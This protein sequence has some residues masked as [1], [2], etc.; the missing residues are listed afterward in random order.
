MFALGLAL[1]A[2]GMLGREYNGTSAFGDFVR[3][4]YLHMVMTGAFISGVLL[5]VRLGPFAR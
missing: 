1:V 3:E 4:Y 2:G 5:S